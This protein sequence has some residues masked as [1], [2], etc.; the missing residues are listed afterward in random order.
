MARGII[1]GIKTSWHQR[2]S[3]AVVGGRCEE[4]EV[5]VVGRGGGGGALKQ[6]HVA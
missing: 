4:A 5:E 1:S 2:I 3:G 6:H